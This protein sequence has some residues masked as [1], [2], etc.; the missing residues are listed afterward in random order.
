M[1]SQQ[2]G[3]LMREDARVSCTCVCACLSLQFIG[4]LTTRILVTR[5]WPLAL[6]DLTRYTRAHLRSILLFRSRPLSSPQARQIFTFI[7]IYMFPPTLSLF[8]M[9]LQLYRMVVHWKT[10][11]IT[12][13]QQWPIS[14]HTSRPQTQDAIDIPV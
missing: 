5:R 4:M 1:G 2:M 14:H 12:S 3:S 13:I 9:T 6:L 10:I 8:D 7:S 11:K